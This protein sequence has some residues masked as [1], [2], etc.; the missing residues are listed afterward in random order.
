MIGLQKKLPWPKDRLKY[1]PYN[2]LF[3]Y[4]WKIYSEPKNVQKNLYFWKNYGQYIKEDKEEKKRLKVYKENLQ[5]KFEEKKQLMVEESK[6][7]VN[8]KLE[9]IQVQCKKSGNEFNL[10]MIESTWTLDLLSTK[11]FKS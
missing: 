7:P 1:T 11:Y 9:Q 5:A 8:R 4:Y 3:S 2:S 10:S 6:N